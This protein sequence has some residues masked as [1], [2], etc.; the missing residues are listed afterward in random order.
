MVYMA[1]DNNLSDA[2]LGDI[3]EME[4]VGSTDAVNIVVQAEFSSDYSSGAP[5]NTVRGRIVRDDVTRTIGSPLADIGNQDMSSPATLTGFIRWAAQRYPAERYALVLWDHGDGWKAYPEDASPYKGALLDDTSSGTTMSLPDIASAIRDSGVRFEM[6]NFDACY[7]GMYE[8]AFE[9]AG[10]ADCLVFSEEVTPGNGDPYNTI[11][12]AL[13]ENPAMGGTELAMLTTSLYIQFYRNQ[14]RSYAAK[15]ALD[16][17]LVPEL[18]AG[19]GEL[20]GLIVN[21]TG[22]ARTAMQYARDNSLA[23]RNRPT[24]HDLRDVLETLYTASS[25][26]AVRAK[27]TGLTATLASAVLASEVYH[28]NAA[29]TIFRLGGL[30]VYLPRRSQVS[31]EEL[32]LYRLL[33][34]NLTRQTGG[35]A[36]ADL[37][38][39]LIAA[40]EDSGMAPLPTGAGGFSVWLEWDTDADLDLII[41]EPDGTWSAPYT[42]ASSAAG[43]FSADSAV[44]GISA[45]YF[46]AF[47]R[48]ASGSYDIL[49]HYYAD[50]SSSGATASLYFMDPSLGIDELSLLEVFHLDLSRPAPGNW[51]AGEAER[52]NVWNDMY[53]DWFWWYHETLL[54]RSMQSVP[55]SCTVDGKALAVPAA[56]PPAGGKPAPGRH[57]GK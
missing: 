48:V 34:C 11:L 29:D 10:L 33:A 26:T 7:M 21:D 54:D 1:A 18:H 49:V 53:S 43:Y 38:D 31:D 5:V 12:A 22:S 20:A 23:C 50:G 2:G 19:L 15:S 42:G 51:Y 44:S 36:W 27:I 6:I 28:P 35:A 32:S 40:D 8:T 56:K 41:W 30:S 4:Q 46:S 57:P 39:L 3:N 13:T 9:L 55:L 14:R 24:Y 16:M 45:E 47:D 52:L 25:S 37:V 17:S